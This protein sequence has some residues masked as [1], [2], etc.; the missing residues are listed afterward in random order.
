MDDK[1]FY[2]LIEAKRKDIESLDISQSEKDNLYKLINETIE[3]DEKIRSYSGGKEEDLKRIDKAEKKII[4]T[5]NQISSIVKQT[6]TGLEDMIA[7]ETI[8][9]KIFPPKN[10]LSKN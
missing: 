4:D 1:E 7:K 5:Y 6:N 2:E 10:Y 8:K 3:R 9:K